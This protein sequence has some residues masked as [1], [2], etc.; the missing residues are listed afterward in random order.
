MLNFWFALFQ[1]CRSA[2]PGLTDFLQAVLIWDR[3]LIGVFSTLFAV[4]LVE[5]KHSL[6]KVGMSYRGGGVAICSADES[7]RV[8]ISED[9]APRGGDGAGVHRRYA[10]AVQHA[11][12]RHPQ[13]ALRYQVRRFSFVGPL[14]E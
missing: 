6:P 4:I 7:C 8:L 13:V 10:S 5:S 14:L 11:A 9:D 1:L 3:A 12:V 2:V